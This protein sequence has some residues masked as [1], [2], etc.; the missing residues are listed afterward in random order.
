[1]QSWV[2]VNG[3]EGPTRQA[4]TTEFKVKANKKQTNTNTRLQQ[5]HGLQH[6]EQTGA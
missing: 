4:F 5:P 3:G 6:E 2:C 1:M